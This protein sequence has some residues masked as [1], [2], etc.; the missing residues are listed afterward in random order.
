[1]GRKHEIP[2][3]VNLG[4]LILRKSDTLLDGKEAQLANNVIFQKW[5]EVEQRSG[6]QARL[7]I[8]ATTQTVRVIHQHVER[9]TNIKTRLLLRGTNIT[10]IDGTNETILESGLASSTSLGASDQLFDDSVICTGADQ[11]R[12]FS[13]ISGIT[14][15]DTQS[16]LPQWCVKFAN[17]MVYGGDKDLPQRIVFS[18]L[19]DAK[20]VN[21][22]ADFI[23][24]LDAD[25]KITG[26]FTLF[27]SLYITSIGSITKID[28]SDFTASSPTFNAQV[29]TLWK[30]DGSVNHQSITVA[31]D[32]AYFLGRYSVYEFDGRAVKDISELVEPFFRTGINRSVITSAVSVHDEENNVVV[33]SIPSVNSSVPDTHFVYHYEPALMSWSTWSG[34]PVSYWYEMEESGEFPI[35]WHGDFAGQVF[36]HGEER[37]DNF[38]R[39]VIGTAIKFEYQTGWEVVNSP[40]KRFILKTIYP[41]IRGTV[42]DTF[43]IEVFT[44]YSKTNTPGF[45]QSVTLPALGAI[46]GA[47]TW[48]EF[49]WGGP[50]SDFTDSI[51]IPATVARNYSI[52]FTH[53]T[54]GEP[55]TLVGWS[56]TVILKGLAD[57][58]PD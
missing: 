8:P 1:M 43:E 9:A 38:E 3:Y 17:Y 5:G 22:N 30:G 4:G 24:I 27:N 18:S 58:Q 25:Q 56:T 54:L 39:N 28:G 53:E 51:G 6:F 37:D 48:G 12:A 14:T 10:T 49:I 41:I 11:P 29:T 23:D 57:G 46:W 32:R 19:G 36:R 16:F 40:S 7:N 31:H 15:I 50:D 35:I 47:V 13:N 52:K 20:V 33:M 26:A 44:D 55:F 45:P 2:Y 42:F 34:F 21:S